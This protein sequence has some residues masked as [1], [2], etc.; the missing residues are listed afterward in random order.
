MQ[1]FSSEETVSAKK[2]NG[3]ELAFVA[4]HVAHLRSPLFSEGVQFI[5]LCTKVS[6]AILAKGDGGDWAS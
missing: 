4:T 6:H 3:K 5:L 2:L 1:M